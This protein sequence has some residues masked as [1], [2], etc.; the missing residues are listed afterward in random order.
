M[1]GVR[2]DGVLGVVASDHAPV[3]A[4]PPLDVLT[5][6]DLAHAKSDLRRREVIAVD[7]LLNALTADVE[8]DAD[9]R[10][11]DKVMHARNHSHNASSHL[12]RGQEHGSLVT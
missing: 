8:H 5:L 12:T 1:L 6:P 2:G 7:Q 10:S 3:V 11:A 9:L 4:R